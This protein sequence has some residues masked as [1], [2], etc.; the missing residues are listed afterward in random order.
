[1]SRLKRNI[2]TCELLFEVWRLDLLICNYYCLFWRIYK[3]QLLAIL[4]LRLSNFFSFSSSPLS[5]LYLL[6]RLH[7]LADPLCPSPLFFI[8]YF[9]LYFQS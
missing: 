9:S 7:A 1:M 2:G 8:F 5:I 6:D 4:P 3:A